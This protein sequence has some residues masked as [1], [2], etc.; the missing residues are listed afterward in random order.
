MANFNR[1][2]YLEEAI[3]SV[4]NQTYPFWELIIVDDGSTDNSV[5]KIKPFLKN[6]KIKLFVHVKNLGNPY[7]I[8]DAIKNTS[9]NIIGVLDSDDKLHHK[10]LEI[11]AKAYRD[12]PKYG[13]IYST[14]W[15]C[16][17][18]LNNEKL[19]SWIDDIEPGDSMIFKMRAAHFKTFLK[20]AFKKTKG[21]NPYT[22]VAA[23]FDYML[24]LE[25]VTKYK[26]INKPLYYYRVHKDGISHGRKEKFRS[27]LGGYIAKN[28]AYLRRLN[29]NI[30][31]I[32]LKDLYM[33]YF[34][35]TFYN[36]ILKL[37]F[38]KIVKIIIPIMEKI[39]KILPK[40]SK[41]LRN[42]LNFLLSSVLKWKS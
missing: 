4:I 25:E 21:M 24:K 41:K 5:E 16:D 8:S 22:N 23:D 27:F 33:D 31:N 15:I 6:K 39:L 1:A 40:S 13:F 34:Y 14:M 9:Y 35:I 38:S 7:A 32:S 29:T 42:V 3:S 2:Q 20:D 28:N 26:F 12:Y 11:M 17:E 36:I 30:P 18:N 10:A 19:C 37:V